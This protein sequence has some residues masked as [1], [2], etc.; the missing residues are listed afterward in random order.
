[1]IRTVVTDHGGSSLEGRPARLGESN[2][3]VS[4]AAIMPPGNALRPKLQS[5]V[6]KA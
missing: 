3:T 4:A 2:D 6:D 5:L 1:M